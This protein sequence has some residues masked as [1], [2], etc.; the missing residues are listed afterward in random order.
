VALRLVGPSTSPA[1]LRFPAHARPRSINYG[2]SN[3]S[4]YFFGALC[5]PG[6]YQGK[7]NTTEA[8]AFCVFTPD[9]TAQ[10]VKS[11]AVA[12]LVNATLVESP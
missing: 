8:L 10:V 7:H 6:D 1:Y 12:K 4:L 5:E 11:D 2:P 9:G 3:T